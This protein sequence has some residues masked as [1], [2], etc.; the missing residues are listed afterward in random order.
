MNKMINSIQLLDK[1]Y[2]KLNSDDTLSKAIPLFKKTDVIM[3]FEDKNYQGALLKNDIMKAK[4]PLNSKVK[5]YLK[6]LPKIK[7]TETVEEI[8]RLMLESNAYQLPVFDKEKIIGVVKADTILKKIANSDIGKQPVKN[9]MTT[10]VNTI[11]SEDTIGKA[12]KIFKEEDISRLPV[13]ENNQVN[14]IITMDDIVSKIF[15]P[16]KKPSGWGEYGEIIAEKKHHLEI[17]VKG[18]MNKRPIIMSPKNQ[19][20]SVINKM[21]KFNLRGMILGENKNLKGLLTKKD[22]LEPIISSTKKLP[23]F[24]QFAGEL[25]SIKDFNKKEPKKELENTFLKYLDFLENI[26]LFVHLKQH[27]E[28]RR[29][30]HLIYCKMRLSSPRGMFIASDEGWGFMHAIRKTSNDIEKQIRRTKRR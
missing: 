21:L 7:P 26:H 8:S 30:V 22:L 5:T 4:I 9:Y 10:K 3:I 15:H 20:K 14:G 12:I 1:N 2:S 27:D 6:H 19:V 24:T 13:I 17:P 23:M 18:V 16:E 11:S 28:T 29:G 25:D